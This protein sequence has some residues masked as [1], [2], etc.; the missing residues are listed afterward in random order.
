[1][2]EDEEQQSH[3]ATSASTSSNVQRQGPA[4]TQNHLSA[5]LSMLNQQASSAQNQ[6]AQSAN[7]D[8]ANNPQARDQQAQ[9]Q[10]QPQ[11]TSI[12]RNYFQNVMQQIMNQQSPPAAPVQSPTAQNQTPRNEAS[13][14]LA[15][16][17]EQMHELGFLDDSLNMR[18]LQIT[19]GNVD[20]AVNLLLEGGDLI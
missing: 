7:L 12:D 5:V 19:E 6:P 9:A 2:S 11:P 15:A 20:A 17:L 10:E 8:I 4:I 1:M 18:A 16:K 3:R 14:E 13:S